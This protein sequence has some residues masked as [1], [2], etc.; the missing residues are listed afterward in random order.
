M[1]L[2]IIYGQFVGGVTPLHVIYGCAFGCAAI[3]SW[4]FVAAAPPMRR[5]LRYA[6]IWGITLGAITF[7]GGFLIVPVFAPGPRAFLFGFILGPIGFSLGCVIGAARAYF[8]FGR[9]ATR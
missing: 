5:R 2:A 8:R 3:I 1:V 7:A 4:S 6:S 9:V